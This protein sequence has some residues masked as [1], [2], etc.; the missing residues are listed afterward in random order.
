MEVV[1]EVEKV[2]A[3]QRPP[4][5]WLVAGEE[6]VCLSD[7]AGQ[8]EAAAMMGGGVAADSGIGQRESH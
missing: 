6:L 4:H 2:D 5:E 8:V 7:S 1:L 3:R